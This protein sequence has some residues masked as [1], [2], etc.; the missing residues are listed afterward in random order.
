MTLCSW[1]G[2]SQS[3]R[4][5]RARPQVHAGTSRTCARR[6]K[7]A[8]KDASTVL[9]IQPSS[10]AALKA[11][12]KAYEQLGFLTKALADV[13]AVNKTDSATA[14]TREMEARLKDA[15]SSPKTRPTSAPQQARES[16]RVSDHVTAHSPSNNPLL[17]HSLAL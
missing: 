4:Q 12:A 6:F 10:T 16:T 15:V 17:L 5:G 7:E 11:R 2:I 1:A 9:E 8:A 13:Q 14:E 3:R